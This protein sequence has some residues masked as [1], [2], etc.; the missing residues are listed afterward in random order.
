MRHPILKIDLTTLGTLRSLLEEKL[1]DP[2]CVQEFRTPTMIKNVVSL[3][4]SNGKVMPSLRVVVHD[5]IENSDQMRFDLG[6]IRDL[7]VVG[8]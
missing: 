4:S 8:R 3:A 2:S 1:Q 6:T 5:L 7:R